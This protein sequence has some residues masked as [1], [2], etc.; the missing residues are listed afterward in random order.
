MPYF[1]FFTKYALRLL[2]KLAPNI[3][4][5]ISKEIELIAKNPNGASQLKGNLSFLRSW[6]AYIQGVPYRIIYE[7]KDGAKQAVI[8]VVAKRSEA[9]RLVERLFR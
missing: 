4:Y 1:I 6:H 8:Y 3:R 7:V 2:K 5:L 9:Y